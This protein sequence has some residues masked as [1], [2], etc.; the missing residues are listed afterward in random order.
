MKMASQMAAL[1][2]WKRPIKRRLSK[3]RQMILMLLPGFLVK[4]PSAHGIGQST[5]RQIHRKNY[6]LLAVQIRTLH[7]VM[8]NAK[9]P[10]RTRRRMGR[11]AQLSG[12]QQY[13]RHAAGRSWLF[14]SFQ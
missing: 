14:L 2:S 11:R 10:W 3:S 1:S 4:F 8:G 5:I 6:E 7:M 13:A 12:T 9:S